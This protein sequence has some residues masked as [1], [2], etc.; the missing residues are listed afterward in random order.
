MR[1]LGERRAAR[2]EDVRMEGKRELVVSGETSFAD[3]GMTSLK[4]ERRIEGSESG[5]EEQRDWTAG[6]PE[7]RE[8]Q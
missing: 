1:H 4:W 7:D 3:R 5:E 6:G 8:R 2:S